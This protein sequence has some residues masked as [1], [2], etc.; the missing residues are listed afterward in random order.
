[1]GSK[2]GTHY[3]HP[4]LY[5]IASLHGWRTNSGRTDKG[6]EEGTC[7]LSCMA[8]MISQVLVYNWQHLA[9]FSCV[10]KALDQF[11]CF[12]KVPEY[13]RNAKEQGAFMIAVAGNQSAFDID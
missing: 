12:T 9:T 6:F 2:T 10:V 1:M 4:V 5:V 3:L 8:S 13:L 11:S 7:D